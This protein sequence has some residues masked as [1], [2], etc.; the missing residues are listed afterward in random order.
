M[1]HHLV[2]RYLK[3]IFSVY[4]DQRDFGRLVQVLLMDIT[5]RKNK[6]GF[7]AAWACMQVSTC[8]NIRASLPVPHTASG[9]SIFYAGG[10]PALFS[11]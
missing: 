9:G 3:I 11:V 6:E 1:T 5:Q 7:F 8:N 4:N 2:F 10:T